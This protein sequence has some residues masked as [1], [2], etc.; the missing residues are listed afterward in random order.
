MTVR[1]AVA[2]AFHTD[3]MAPAC[4][5]LQEALAG[6]TI[7]VRPCARMPV[8]GRGRRGMRSRPTH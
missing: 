6:T 5:K 7:L 2:G 8:C 3:F 4:E 1:L